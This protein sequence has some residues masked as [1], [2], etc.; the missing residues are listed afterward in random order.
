[1]EKLPRKIDSS[2][3]SEVTPPDQLLRDIHS[4]IEAGRSRVAQVVNTELVLLHWHIG[5]RIMR[6]VLKEER[7]DV[8]AG[9]VL[10]TIT[11]SSQPLE[12]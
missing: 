2:E 11:D 10:L 7:A 12:L 4:L 5:N 6:E 8:E 3:L 1:M 9:V